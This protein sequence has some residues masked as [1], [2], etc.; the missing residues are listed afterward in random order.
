M[1]TFACNYSNY[2]TAP[3]GT[4]VVKTGGSL[5]TFK[6]ITGLQEVFEAQLDIANTSADNFNLVTVWEDGDSG[7]QDFSFLY[8]ENQNTTTGQ[9][10]TLGLTRDRAGTPAYANLIIPASHSII[11][12]SG[13]LTTANLTDGS[14]ETADLIDQI[15]FKNDN[16]ATSAD[17]T[18]R[19][20]IVLLR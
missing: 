12:P 4:D 14:A 6:Q 20:R 5:S 8:C 1:T 19:G 13:N 17:I 16:D 3:I 10:L 15:R 7:I 2:F 11:I 18:V 9:S